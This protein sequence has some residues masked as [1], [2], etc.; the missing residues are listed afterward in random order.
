M[1]T[2]EKHVA[3]GVT[4]SILDRCAPPA[5]QQ[6]LSI[7]SHWCPTWI[8]RA[9]PDHAVDFQWYSVASIWCDRCRRLTTHFSFLRKFHLVG[10]SDRCLELP[11]MHEVPGLPLSAIFL[12]WTFLD[13]GVATL[14]SIGCSHTMRRIGWAYASI[15]CNFSGVCW[16]CIYTLGC[17]CV[18]CLWL[19][20]RVKRLCLGCCCRC[21]IFIY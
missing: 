2:S 13:S 19:T 1:C 9:L 20:F 3:I 16:G 18:L 6:A 8:W 15:R 7:R 10:W 17:I 14:T 4:A 5:P 21:G 12:F 11:D